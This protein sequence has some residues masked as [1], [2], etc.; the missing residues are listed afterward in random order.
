MYITTTFFV[1]YPSSNRHASSGTPFLQYSSALFLNSFTELLLHSCCTSH[2]LAMHAS[3]SSST[4]LNFLSCASPFTGHTG[5]F[6]WCTF[7]GLAACTTLFFLTR[8]GHSLHLC[9]FSPHLKYS[10]STTPTLLIIFSSTPHCITL[11]FNTSNLFWDIVTPFSASFYFLQFWAR[12]L[13]PFQ[14]KH[15]FSLLSLSSSLSLVREH[16]SLSKL[17]I[18]ALYCCKDIVLCLCKGYRFND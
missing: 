11:L 7:Y 8:N 4:F 16:F 14:P 6:Y 13:N 18:S 10:T 9:P 17:L 3:S 5:F 12:Y 15:N 2:G 1:H